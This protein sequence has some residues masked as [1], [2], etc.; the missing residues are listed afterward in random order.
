MSCKITPFEKFKYK[1][2]QD[3]HEIKYFEVNTASILMARA[4]L[5]I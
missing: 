2:R 3:F 1:K 4:L 5:N